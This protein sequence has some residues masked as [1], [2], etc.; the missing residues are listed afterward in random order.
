MIGLAVVPCP[1]LLAGWLQAC[2]F[3]FFSSS[4]PEFFFFFFYG[5]IVPGFARKDA[6]VPFF[7]CVQTPT[8]VGG[9]IWDPFLQWIETTRAKTHP[10]PLPP[11]DLFFNEIAGF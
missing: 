2:F 3:F 10:L 9:P 7:T 1:W 8:T 6:C 4:F 11:P 5:V